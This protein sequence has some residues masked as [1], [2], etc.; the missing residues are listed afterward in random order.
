MVTRDKTGWSHSC[1]YLQTFTHFHCLCCISPRVL[2]W[3]IITSHNRQKNPQNPLTSVVVG[4]IMR[5]THEVTQHNIVFSLSHRTKNG[6]QK[7]KI[8]KSHKKR[9]W[10]AKVRR[11]RGKREVDKSSHFWHQWVTVTQPSHY[12]HPLLF[13]GVC[14]GSN[15]Q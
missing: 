6:L 3:T 5:M 7:T 2:L 13:Q 1:L 8:G 10:H 15:L 4:G 11:M 9:R 12:S 14:L